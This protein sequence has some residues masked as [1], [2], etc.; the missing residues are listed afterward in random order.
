[1]SGPRPFSA[2]AHHGIRLVA[3]LLILLLGLSRALALDTLSAERLEQARARYFSG[4]L[5]VARSM[6]LEL[7]G[8][9]QGEASY[10]LALIEKVSANPDGTSILTHLR[11]AVEHGYAPA[12][13][14]L[15]QSYEEGI[16]VRPDPLRAMDWYRA[17]EAASADE[18]G[19]MVFL[20]DR[21]GLF[22][23]RPA[24]EVIA[25][26][27]ELAARNDVE[28]QYRLARIYDAGQL[29]TSNPAT[30]LEWYRRAAENGHAQSRF[31]LGYLHCRGIGTA[32]DLA[33]A[34]R[35][36]AASGRPVRCESQGKDQ[37]HE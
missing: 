10:Y 28:A 29:L 24:A 27:H 25:E 5:V 35:W 23:E 7:E 33:L 26:L 18:V 16:G 13:W 21:D 30:A 3:G 17:S 9:V 19:T 8:Q 37:I 31:V 36:L 34:N 20:R 1:M 12:M 6:F 15:G 22:T 4:D 11:R 32:V 14:A 2:S